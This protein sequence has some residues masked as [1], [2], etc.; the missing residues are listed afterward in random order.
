MPPDVDRPKVYR[1][2][3]RS[4]LGSSDTVSLHLQNYTC[5]TEEVDST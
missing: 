3:G 1:A 4:R 5:A 2:P